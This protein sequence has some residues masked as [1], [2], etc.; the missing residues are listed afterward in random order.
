VPFLLEAPVEAL[1][2]PHEYLADL[3]AFLSRRNGEA[4]LLGEVNLPYTETMRFFG[5]NDGVGDELH[6]CFDFIG[7]QQMYL[8]LARQEA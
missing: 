2:D 7:M 3:R 4:V 6:M 8:S 5:D 1:P